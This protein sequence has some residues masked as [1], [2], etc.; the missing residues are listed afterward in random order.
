MM[1]KTLGMGGPFNNQTH[2]HTIWGVYG[3]VF[4]PNPLLKGSICMVNVDKHGAYGYRIE[5]SFF[6]VCSM[7]CCERL[8]GFGH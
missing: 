3:H 4:G 7:R 5:V 6:F 1:G 2:L 8:K